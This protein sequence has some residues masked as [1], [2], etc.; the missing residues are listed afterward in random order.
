MSDKLVAF[1]SRADENYVSGMIKTLAIGN[2][3]I[4]AGIIAKLTGADT[5]KI[6]Q[7]QPYS[8]NYN[9]C[10]AQAQAD[11]NRNAR[12]EL[13]AYPETMEQY[14][15][16][17][18]GFPNYWGTMPMA[19][20]TF[21]EH[22][23][24]S[25]KIIK[26]FCTHEGS[27]LGGSINDIRKLCPEA[28]VETGLA[29]RGG[30]VKMSKAEIESL[31]DTKWAGKNVVYYDEIDSTNNRAKEAGDNGAAHGTLFVADMQVA[32]KGRRGRVWKSPSGSSI[33]M[34]ILLYPD[35]PPVKAPQLTLLMA[36]AVA[37]GIQEVTG[38]ETKIKWPN[39]IVVNGRKICGILT[40]MSTEIDYINHVVIGVGINV[41]QD[42]FPD[43]IKATASSLKLELG[44]S[45]KRSELIA[46]VMKSF[47]KCYEIFIET[48]DLSGLQELYNSML[49]NRDQE[50]KVLEPGNEYKAHAIGI[51]QTGELIVRTPDGKEKEIYA[52]EVSVRGVYGYV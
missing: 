16:I 2:T 32:G 34:T 21:L 35:I 50:V 13:K 20:F 15:E 31:V 38:L 44:K 45:V 11:Q 42:T 36:I 39:D 23:D 43:D 49:V 18:L 14:S 46:A 4:A 9:E 12:P 47:E 37:E 48:E 27:G 51:N 7:A 1:Y 19:V 5:F 22:F 30:S 3:E 29:I 25:G 17:Y 33:Y 26:P 8:K 40:E 6:E 41:N 10:I 24:F 52:G 28:K